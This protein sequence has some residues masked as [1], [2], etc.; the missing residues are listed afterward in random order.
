MLGN[1]CLGKASSSLNMP[2][3][4]E[5]QTI[6]CFGCRP[7]I[8]KSIVLVAYNAQLDANMLCRFLIDH[9]LNSEVLSKKLFK[10]FSTL[11]TYGKSMPGLPSQKAAGSSGG[12]YSNKV[13]CT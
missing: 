9:K 3:C 6:F 12:C 1:R 11:S 5:G 7:A 4:H 13:L 10:D 8:H 2:F